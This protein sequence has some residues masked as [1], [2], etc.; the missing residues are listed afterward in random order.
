[1]GL[2]RTDD[3]RYITVVIFVNATLEAPNIRPGRFMD[4]VRR[5]LFRREDVVAAALAVVRESGFGNLSARRVARRLGASTAP[6][7]SNFA[8][9]DELAGAVKLAIAEQVLA[10]TEVRRSGEPFLDMGAG[11]LEFARRNPELYMAVFMTGSGSGEAAARV[12][13]VLLERMSRLEKLAALDPL[14]RVILLRKMA[15]FTH[16]LAVHVT[17]GQAQGASW[18]EL[19]LLLNEAGR[20]MIA[21]ARNRPPRTAAELALLANPCAAAPPATGPEAP[22]AKKAKIHA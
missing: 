15:I 3:G 11:V 9:M 22:T 18:A 6:V 21:D 1:M 14:E 5:L 20:A 16:G 4:M 7:Y 17:V 8:S 13:E 12:M 2:A 19:L 10:E